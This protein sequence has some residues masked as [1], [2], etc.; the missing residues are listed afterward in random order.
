MELCEMNLDEYNKAIWMVAKVQNGSEHEHQTW[1]IMSQIACGLVFIHENGEVHRD[2][3]PSNGTTL[4]D[5]RV[6][7]SQYFIQAMTKHGS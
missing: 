1:D 4:E 5:N 6:L 2:L 7:M 3:K